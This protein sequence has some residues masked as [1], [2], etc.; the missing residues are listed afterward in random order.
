MVAIRLD[1]KPDKITDIL[2]SSLLDGTVA[3]AT[4]ASSSSKDRNIVPLGDPLASSTWEEVF[5][6]GCEV[7]VTLYF[8]YVF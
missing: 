2:S 6:R 8:L 5:D 4:A 1:E 3:A 7:L